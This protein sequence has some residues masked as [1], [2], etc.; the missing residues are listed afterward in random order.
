LQC[1]GQ[2]KDC[3][4]CHG[5]GDVEIFRCPGATTPYQA[6]HAASFYGA[7]KTGCLPADG[8]I[9]D[10]AAPFVE[11]MRILEV[12]EGEMNRRR[13]ERAEAQQREATR[14]SLRQM[15]AKRKP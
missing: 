10:Q 12:A 5:R 2:N 7:W 11:A 6:K 4:A 13:D 9:L 8:G 1:G 14:Q 3:E 15:A